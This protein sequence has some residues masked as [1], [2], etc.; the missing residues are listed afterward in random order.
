[1]GLTRAQRV[2]LI[3]FIVRR[4]R[5]RLV[6]HMDQLDSISELSDEQRV[7]LA[8]VGIDSAERLL[9][10]ANSQKDRALLVKFLGLPNE[11]ALDQ[12]IAAARRLVSPSFLQKLKL[13][14]VRHPR[15][16]RPPS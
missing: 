8:G 12:V 3:I 1:M 10:R 16:A 7:R 13:P 9:G 4:I 15:G 11:K 6:E 5:S 2:A 14:P